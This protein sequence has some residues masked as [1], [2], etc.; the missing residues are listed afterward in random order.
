MTAIAPHVTAFLRE[1]DPRPDITAHRHQGS[2]KYGFGL[3]FEQELPHHLRAFARAGWNE[4][5]HE[6]FA[7]TEVNNTVSFGIDLAGERWQ[8][9]LD[10]VGSAFVTNGISTD[11]AEYLRLGGR[12]F[13]ARRRQ[14]AL[15]SGEHMGD[16]LH[17]AYVARYFCLGST[18][19]HKQS[20][21]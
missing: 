11:H 1:I 16:L 5:R 4:G 18:A 9:K 10:K 8:R 3:N 20:G 12:G 6:S 21:I 19:I 7:Y 14:S 15:R 2:L 13:L 17:L